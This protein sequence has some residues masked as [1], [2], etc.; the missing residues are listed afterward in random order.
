MQRYLRIALPRLHAVDQKGL[1]MVYG[2]F[3]PIVLKKSAARLLAVMRG[4]RPA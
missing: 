4:A 1:I 2:R 3:A